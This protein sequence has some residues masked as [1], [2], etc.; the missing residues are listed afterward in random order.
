M[1][2][3]REHITF[4]AVVGVV[5]GVL[6]YFYALVTDPVLLAILFVVTIIGSFLPDLDSDSGT[7][8][9]LVFGSFTLVCGGIALYYLL[10]HQPQPLYLLVGLP[11]ATVLLVWGVVGT[12]VKRFTRHRGMMHSLP[13]MFITG[14][15]VYI[16]ARSVLAGNTLSLYFALAAALGFASHLILDEI[17]SENLVDGNPFTNKKSL[18]TALKLFSNSGPVNLFTY[19]LLAALMYTALA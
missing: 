16:A 7:P 17:H 3:F 5:G 15:S 4:G 12:I 10:T 6:L 8:F 19:L 1:A 18:G 14:L 11:I 13:V 2:L 9:Y